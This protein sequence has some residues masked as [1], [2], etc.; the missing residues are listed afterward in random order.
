M[1][2]LM[3]T[4]T[5]AMNSMKT[6]KN[7]NDNN[8]END[9]DDN[10]DETNANKTVTGVGI[11]YSECSFKRYIIQVQ[12]FNISNNSTNNIMIKNHNSFEKLTKYKPK[13]TNAEEQQGGSGKMMI[14][15]MMTSLNR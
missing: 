12:R 13:Y 11:N 10:G 1:N 4:V 2:V 3:T 14:I 15:I 6:D 7:T 5:K 9:A 8:D